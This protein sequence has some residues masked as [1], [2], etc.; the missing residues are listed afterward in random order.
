MKAATKVLAEMPHLL[1][2]TAISANKK[3]ASR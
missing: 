2:A 3:P 1:L